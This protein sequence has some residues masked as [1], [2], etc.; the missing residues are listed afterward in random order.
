[1]VRVEGLLHRRT[2]FELHH[3]G[4]AAACS[5]SPGNHRSFHAFVAGSHSM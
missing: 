4:I 3:G 5:G 1:M 2:Y